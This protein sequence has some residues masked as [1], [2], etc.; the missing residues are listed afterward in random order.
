MAVKPESS[1]INPF[2]PI[3][4]YLNRLNDLGLLK[5]VNL[6]VRLGGVI[7]GN[8]NFLDDEAIRDHNKNL[9]EIKGQLTEILTHL[10]HKMSSYLADYD[11][12]GTT[13]LGSISRLIE[14]ISAGLEC[15]SFCV[16]VLVACLNVAHVRPM[17]LERTKK[18]KKKK[19]A[20]LKY[21]GTL[22]LVRDIHEEFCHLVAY[23][24]VISRDKLSG[25]ELA[26]K[27]ERV[28]QGVEPT[29]HVV[30]EEKDR[31]SNVSSSYVKA[32]EDVKK[33]F[34]AKLK[35]LLKLSGG[36]GEWVE[37]VENAKSKILFES[38]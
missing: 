37:F 8:G 24:T 9:I 38:Q 15:V 18:S 17:W 16:I 14:S 34:I 19:D 35:I 23:L 26:A 27:C 6:F 21:S 20:Y 28:F 30:K 31:F 11:K 36:A 25:S 4:T 5:L 32:C 3:S 2:S 22:D 10:K 7:I 29:V 12:T 33:L 1:K 13:S